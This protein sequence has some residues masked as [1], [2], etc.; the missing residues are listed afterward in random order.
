MKL[1][2]HSSYLLLLFLKL[3]GKTIWT[4]WQY[5]TRFPGWWLSTLQFEELSGAH[6]ISQLGSTSCSWFK[7]LLSS[8]SRSAKRVTVT[9]VHQLTKSRCLTDTWHASTFKLISI[10]NVQIY[11]YWCYCF[12]HFY[13]QYTKDRSTKFLFPCEQLA[14]Y[15]SGRRQYNKW[16]FSQSRFR[17]IPRH[18]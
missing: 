14:L 1:N 17:S 4:L 6:L 2:Q 8:C 11:I 3:I 13:Y 7:R 10:K 18:L 16:T 15:S 5:Y 12:I 9:C